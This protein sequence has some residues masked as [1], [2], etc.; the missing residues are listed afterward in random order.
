MQL[1]PFRITLDFAAYAQHRININ[2]EGAVPSLVL[3]ALAVGN[4]VVVEDLHVTDNY[5]NVINYR[6][7]DNLVLIDTTPY[8]LNYTI[9]TLYRDCVG[10]DKKQDFIYPF[11]NADEVFIGSGTLPYPPELSQDY[12]LKPLN[13]PKGFNLFSTLAPAAPEKLASFF[14]YAARGQH[15]QTFTYTYST[16]H[17]LHLNVLVQHRKQLPVAFNRVYTFLAGWLAFLEKQIGTYDRTSH[18]N[19]L[20]LQ[21]PP[22]F[23]QQ[24]Q[25]KAFATG[26]NMLNG[27]I[28]YA[29]NDGDYLYQ[30]FGHRD[31]A[32][33]LY[34]GFTH[35]LGH[36]Y[37]SAGNTLQKSILHAASD[38]LPQDRMLIGEALNGYIHELYMHYAYH[39][40]MQRLFSH[41]IPRWLKTA[42]RNEL[43][44]KWFLMDVAL[45][46]RHKSSVWKLFRRMVTKHPGAYSAAS[47]LIPYPNLLELTPTPTAIYDA[48]QKLLPTELIPELDSSP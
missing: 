5:G 17:K 7:D 46:T 29:P 11:I 36:L 37:T 16:G 25:G 31:Y 10:A 13:L 27:I 45:H 4:G 42:R 9:H 15:P 20:L 30:M 35:E 40:D 24:T 43:K 6:I 44:L 41:T 23:V 28:T 14:L 8:H 1:P 34:D 39:Q 48:M 2:V 21:A 3:Q 12:L 38:C 22:G 18:I 19:M 26:E 32:Y 33:F 47:A